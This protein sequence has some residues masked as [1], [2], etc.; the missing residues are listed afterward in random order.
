LF[1]CVWTAGFEKRRFMEISWQKKFIN[2]LIYSQTKHP[3]EDRLEFFPV[4]L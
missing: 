4:R 1:I 3:E 2:G